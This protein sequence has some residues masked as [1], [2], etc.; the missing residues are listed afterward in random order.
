MAKIETTVTTS[1]LLR[2]IIE[3]YT[4]GVD[5]DTPM[6]DTL[7]VYDCSI[8]LF[9]IFTHAEAW[10]VLQPV[11]ELMRKLVQH[12]I[13]AGFLRLERWGVEDKCGYH[14]FKQGQFIA[15]I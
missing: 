6:K 2:E 7:A 5:C 4:K 12:E 11:K 13:D 8:N 9:G 15:T 1:S 10:T 14:V 3:A